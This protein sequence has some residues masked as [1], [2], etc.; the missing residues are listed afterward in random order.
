MEVMSHIIP[1]FSNM[2]VEMR[3]LITGTRNLISVLRSK[4]SGFEIPVFL[5]LIKGSI[6]L[7]GLLQL[8]YLYFRLDSQN[9]LSI[10]VL[11]ALFLKNIALAAY[12]RN[13]ENTQSS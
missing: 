1:H 7:A 11:L 13:S 2:V 6:I 8:H 12:N 4:F 9:P 10:K 5:L 3:C